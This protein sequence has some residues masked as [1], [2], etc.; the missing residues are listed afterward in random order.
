MVHS[1]NGISALVEI[2]SKNR[3]EMSEVCACVGRVGR[4]FAA[5]T[6]SQG[7][8]TNTSENA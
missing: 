5:G 1:E 3:S 7:D 4:G 2:Q 8:G 6:M